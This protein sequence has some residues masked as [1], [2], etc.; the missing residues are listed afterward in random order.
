[1]STLFDSMSVYEKDLAI[2]ILSILKNPCNL[3][4]IIEK[5]DGAYPT[6]ILFIIDLLIKNSDIYFNGNYYALK[7]IDKI[8]KRPTSI[9]KHT[10]EQLNYIEE[11]VD[12]ISSPHP[13]DYDWRFTAQTIISTIDVIKDLDVNKN[14]GLFGVTT[15]YPIINGQNSKSNADLFNKSSSL[16]YDLKKMGFNDGLFEHDL[17][18]PI[19]F[20]ANTYDVIVADPPWYIDFYKA[21]ISRATEVI[22]K[23]GY[24][25]L[26]VL[27]KLTRPDA[28][29]DRQTINDF[30]NMLGFIEY[31]RLE[32][33]LNYES[34]IFE[35][36]SLMEQGINCKDW[37]YGDLIIYKYTGNKNIKPNISIPPEE[38]KWEELIYNKIKIKLLVQKDEHHFFSFENAD[39]SHIL[40]SV[41]RRSPLRNRIT[42]WTSENFAFK[43]NK[44]SVLKYLFDLLKSDIKTADAIEILKVDFQ[45][46]ADEYNKLIILLKKINIYT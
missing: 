6:D 4:D 29:I 22:K 13:A 12:R 41:S 21:F 1:M 25:L 40:S 16:I 23:D 35:R 2:K 18:N 44:P 43:I 45:L 27:P 34:P 32:G 46:S 42:L 37:R 38:P 30:C 24:L 9:Q 14:I 8:S 26:S 11:V 5:A 15:L 7:E 10:K 28:E 20:K 39:H 19:P 3:C 31:N 36:R 33:F 17:F